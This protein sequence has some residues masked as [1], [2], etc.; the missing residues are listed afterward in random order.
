M[1]T[2]RYTRWDGR[3]RVALDAERVFEKF[4]EYLS[5][6]DDVRQALEWLMRHGLDMNGVQVMGLDELLEQ[7]REEMRRRYQRY[8]LDSALDDV[9]RRLDEL[10]D[11]ERAALDEARTRRPELGAKRDFLDRLPS[12]LTEAIERLRDYDF[13]DAD[14]ADDFARLLESLDDIRRLEDFTRRHGE[15]FQGPEALDFD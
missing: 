10:L 14:A 2:V 12:R 1:L 11:L 13:E 7:V 4:G 15:L 5:Y 8:N 9:Q 6:T 3:Q